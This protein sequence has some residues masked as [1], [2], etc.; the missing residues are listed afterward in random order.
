MDSLAYPCNSEQRGADP[1]VYA[2]D[3]LNLG[4]SS[5]AAADD[6]ESNPQEDCFTAAVR[7]SAFPSGKVLHCAACVSG[8]RHAPGMLSV[9]SPHP[10]HG[11]PCTLTLCLNACFC[12]CV[13]TC[14]DL[15]RVQHA[16]AG[17]L[18]PWF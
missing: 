8:Y 5:S 16:A 1:G 18:V 6:A 14:K 11:Q 2:A 7:P 4:T 9:A 10:D 3:D 13:V 15:S 12:T 17:G